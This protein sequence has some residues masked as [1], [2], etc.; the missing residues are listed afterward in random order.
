[1]ATAKFKVRETF[2]KGS[3]HRAV[4]NLNNC[5]FISQDQK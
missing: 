2:E 1:M 5:K 3:Q 4:N